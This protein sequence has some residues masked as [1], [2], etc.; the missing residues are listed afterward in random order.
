MSVGQAGSGSKEHGYTAGRQLLRPS[1]QTQYLREFV[2]VQSSVKAQETRPLDPGWSGIVASRLSRCF[3]K[4]SLD[5]VIFLI[6]PGIALN[7]LDH[8]IFSDLSINP[9]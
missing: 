7:N 1:V 9:T 2:G 4:T 6:Y 5:P 3:L 8:S